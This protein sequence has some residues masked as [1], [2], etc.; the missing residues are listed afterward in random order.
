MES[1][2]LPGRTENQVWAE[3]HRALIAGGGEYL[4][5]RLFNSGE[6]TNPWFQEASNKVIQAGEL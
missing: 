6:N 5:T 4:E 3:L 1:Q 2:I